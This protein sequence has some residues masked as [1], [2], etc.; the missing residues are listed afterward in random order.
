MRIVVVRKG[1]TLWRLARRYGT[2]AER[3]ADVNGLTDPDALAVGQAIV[4]PGTDDRLAARNEPHQVAGGE[5]MSSIANQYGVSLKSLMQQNGIFN[6][7]LA[8]AGSMLSIP[9][10]TKPTI[11][12]NGYVQPGSAGEAEVRNNAASLTYVSPFSYAV[13]SD[14]SLAALDD[15]ALIQAALD[16]GAA[17]MMVISNF[18]GG[19]FDS[20]IV[21]RLLNDA[22]AGSRLIANVVSVMQA[23]GY[24]ALNVD[25]EYVPAADKERYHAL[26]RQLTDTLHHYGYLVSSAL[27]PKTSSAQQG[28]LYEGHDYA[29]QGKIVDFVILMTYEW[30]W[31]GGK[32][33]AVAPLNEVNKVVR[34]AVSVIPPD[35]ILM[36]MPLYGYDWT[37]PY[38][39]GTTAETLSHKEA[40]DRAVRMGAAIQ[41]D[42]QAESP[43]YTYYDGSGKEHIVWFEDARSVQAKYNLV[44]TYGLRGVSFWVLGVPFAQN[45]YVLNA[46]FHIA[47]RSAGS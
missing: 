30:G 38:A 26:L 29:A 14:G 4:I 32:P 35:K 11:E 41:Y 9:A 45:W 18:V 36:G 37:L 17:P 6:P 7:A 13:S 33:M 3:L 28:L 47:K 44:K 19:T 27:A 25:F 40:V 1:D 2:T 5:S 15:A 43:Y 12:A 22:N 10:E 23:K 39:E 34:Y 16:G 31:F 8:S 21:S 46:N 20:D 24:T 42:E